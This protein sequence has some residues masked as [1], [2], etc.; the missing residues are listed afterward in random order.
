MV[1]GLLSIFAVT[2]P[3]QAEWIVRTAGTLFWTDDIGVF[4]ATRRLSRDGDPTQP[5]LDSV[6]TDKGSSV[7]FEPKL[8]LSTSLPNRLGTMELSALGQGFLFSED[9]RFNQGMLGLEALQ[10]FSPETRLRMRYAY[11][12]NQ[13]LGDNE[14]K[15]PGHHGLVGEDLTSQIW[16]AR[17]ERHVNPDLE[18]KLLGRFGLRR[19]NDA[20][21]QRDTNFLTIG[22]HLD[23]RLP[24]R[25]ML[26]LGYHF[27]RGLADGRNRPE[28]QDDVS[29]INHYFTAELDIEL[30]EQLS[31]LMA[32]H[33][34][35]NNWTSS[36]AGDER[37]GEHEDVIQ[38][39]VLL[40]YQ[41]THRLQIFGGFQ[42]SSRK[43][44]FEQAV[45]KNTNVAMGIGAM[46]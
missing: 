11:V 3:A 30:M 2:T 39:E 37:N 4:S 8:I 34:E 23:W 28:F 19:Y 41:V 33:Y 40:T 36:I 25:A 20:F 24:H 43:Q 27:E 9:S 10:S 46:F 6:L 1:L 44:S 14:D 26:G 21:A 18:F 42:R 35:R 45:V 7:V 32:A 12:P 17:L 16:S 15:R 5:A 31:L 38:G 13:F 29:Y 22:P